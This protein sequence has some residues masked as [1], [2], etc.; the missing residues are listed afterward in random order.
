MEC[1][2]SWNLLN[3]TPINCTKVRSSSQNNNTLYMVGL[4]WSPEET[5]DWF[6]Q[7]HLPVGPP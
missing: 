4:E 1:K 6:K 3:E 5:N 7:V 2:R